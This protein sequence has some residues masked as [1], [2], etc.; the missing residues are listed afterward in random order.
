MNNE[1][2]EIT[3]MMEEEIDKGTFPGAVLGIVNRD[4]LLYKKAF[5]YSQLEPVKREMTIKTRFDLASLTKVVATTSAVMHLIARGKLNLWDYLKEFFP[6][7]PEEKEEITIYHLLSH[8]SGYQAIVKLWDMDKDYNDKIEHIL[9]LP[10]KREIGTKIEYSDPNFIL[11]GE[12]VQRVSGKS[13]DKYLKQHI[14]SPLGMK[15]TYFNPRE[16]VEDLDQIDF[17]ATEYCDW[18]DRYVIGEVHDENSYS[19]GGVSGHAGLFSS[20]GDLSRFVRMLLNEGDLEGNKI[21]PG[22]LIKMM[23]KNWTEK[24]AANRA[25]G[26]DLAD[27]F[28]SSSGILMGPD[29]FGHTGFT[30]TSIWISPSLD[31]GVIILT[32]RV[33][34]SRDNVDIIEFRPRIH[35]LIVSV[36]EHSGLI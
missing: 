6:A 11:L 30:G 4:Q 26:W 3:N 25:L 32:N 19:L 29:A 15:K 33:H 9:Q 13:L 20:I 27:N 12:L 17:A 18:R 8:T 21:F 5:G 23:R 2:T 35:N 31:L 10:L 14:F 34:P 28:R 24:F 7:L 22:R 36:L 16:N 1:F